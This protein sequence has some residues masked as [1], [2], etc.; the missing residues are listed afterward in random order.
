MRSRGDAGIVEETMEVE[1]RDEDEDGELTEE[2]LRAKLSQ[3][4]TSRRRDGVAP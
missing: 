2:A 1:R 4:S 3:K